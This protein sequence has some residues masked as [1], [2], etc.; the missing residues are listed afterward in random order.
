MEYNM[1]K[2][3]VSKKI[4]YEKTTCSNTE[5]IYVVTYE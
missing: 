5:R 3:Y 4:V 2:Y 1:Y